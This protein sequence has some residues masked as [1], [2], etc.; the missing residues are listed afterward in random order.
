MK[1]VLLFII[2]IILA[3]NAGAQAPDRNLGIGIH[4]GLE[5]YKG[6]LGNGF[7]DTNQ[8]NYEFVGFSFTDNLTE[9]FGVEFNVTSGLI[10]YVNDPIG[11]F[12][13]SLYQFSLNA[14]YNFFRFEQ[15]LRPFVF[16][17]FGFIHLTDKNSARE[18]SNAQMPDL[19][20]GLTYNVSPKVSI[21]LKETF[22]YS[23]SDNI[24][25]KVGGW[26]DSYLQ[27]SIGVVFNFGTGKDTDRDGVS[28]KYDHCPEVPGLKHLSGCPDSDND[29][30]VDAEDECPTVKGAKAL[31]GCPDSDSDGVPDK[32]DACPDVAGMKYLN[33]CP[34]SDNDGIADAED[35]CPTVKG[36]KALNG[37]PDSDNDGV[38]DKDDACPD[39]KGTKTLN[40][41][42]DKDNDGIADKDDACPDIAGLPARN[43]CPEAEEVLKQALHGIKFQSGKD[44]L[45]TESYPV[46][47]KVVS[48]CVANPEFKLKIDGHT[49]SMGDN[50]MNLNLSRNRARAVKE[51]LV[52]NGVNESRLS[53]EGFGETRPVADNRT[54]KGRAENRRVVLTIEY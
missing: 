2:V 27:H 32:D 4:A 28:D 34:D 48:I 23:S 36:A 11:K 25:L 12:R 45:T 9:H 43:G 13:F 17:G 39:M 33:G 44:I 19:G 10:G 52:E 49:D 1:K 30:I 38:P 26:N 53:Y 54:A 6:D 22:I 8:Y 16:A 14:K 47:N 51:Y 21:V 24:D 5:Q 20:F 3:A 35:S 37:C 46:L 7:F 42:P 41:C 29:G 40:G 31:N 15:K 50:T 18:L